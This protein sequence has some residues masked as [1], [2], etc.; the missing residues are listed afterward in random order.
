MRVTDAE[1]AAQ[2]LAPE[3]V[4]EIVAAF[5]ARGLFV[6]E[7]VVPLE[8]CSQLAV[9]MLADAAAIVA[10]G[11]WSARGEFGHGHLQ[12]GQP[13]MGPFVHPEVVANSIVEQVVVA[14]LRHDAKLGFFNGNCAMPG[15]GIQRLHMDDQW[16]YHS[17]SEAAAAGEPWPH[18]TTSVHVNICPTGDVTPGNGATEVWPG[19]HT[20]HTAHRGNGDPLADETFVNRR[21]E[22]Q[23]PDRNCF[24]AGAVVFR[25]AR[26]WV[27]AYNTA[28]HTMMKVRVVRILSQDHTALMCSFHL[29]ARV[30]HPVQHRG[31][32]NH[33]PYPRPNIVLVYH[34]QNRT[35]ALTNT[36]GLLFSES[37]RAAFARENPSVDR[38]V[39]FIPGPVNHFGASHG[40]GGALLGEPDPSYLGMLKELPT[41]PSRL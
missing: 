16:D 1:R 17:P 24:P 18:R 4:E 25:D 37:A 29:C 15:S 8:V 26:I 23:P 14:I 9:K 19:S 21:R 7:D 28:T 34:R 35:R 3:K 5:D 39:S 11:G 2:V 20:V 36:P 31:V 40:P 32:P 41:A 30:C 10:H 33:S 27:R 13:R 6:L 38:N 12:L 22:V